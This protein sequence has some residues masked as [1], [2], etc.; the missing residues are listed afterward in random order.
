MDMNVFQRIFDILSQPGDINIDFGA[1][2]DTFAGCSSFA[3]GTG[4]DRG[5]QRISD[6]V[7]AAVQSIRISDLAD[8]VSLLADIRAPED[9]SLAEYEEAASLISSLVSDT[10][11]LSLTLHRDERNSGVDVFILIGKE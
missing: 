3:A 7:N 9:F 2:R 1:L 4:T 5:A 11:R 8:C 10:C 6:A